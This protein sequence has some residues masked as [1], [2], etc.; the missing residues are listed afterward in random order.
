MKN[1]GIVASLACVAFAAFTAWPVAA[2]GY[3]GF[4]DVHTQG[5]WG[6]QVFIDLVIA[7]MLFLVWMIPDARRHQLA[8]W[9]FVIAVLATGSLGALAYLAVR[10]WREATITEGDPPPAGAA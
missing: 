6:Y 10:A 4:I 2:Q 7:L 5:P 3:L 8:A 9:P 1:Y